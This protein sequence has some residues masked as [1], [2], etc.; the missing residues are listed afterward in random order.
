MQHARWRPPFKPQSV[1]L[2]VLERLQTT[3]LLNLARMASK[4]DG[5]Q[6][7]SLRQPPVVQQHP[8]RILLLQKHN[9][10]CCGLAHLRKLLH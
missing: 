4:K 9:C 7:S 2:T 1:C 5:I 3:A 8:K 10:C 6:C